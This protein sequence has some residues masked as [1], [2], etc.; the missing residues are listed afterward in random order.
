MK[1]KVITIFTVF[2]LIIGG[3]LLNSIYQE[4]LNYVYHQH[5]EDNADE[6]ACIGIENCSHLPIIN[7]NTYN[8]PIPGEDKN[9]ENY[10][11]ADINI[12][13]GGNNVTV[14]GQNGETS[15]ARLRYRGR[16]SLS[17]DKKGYLIKF[18]DE[19]NLKINKSLLGMPE[20]SD[21]V[22]HG[23]FIDK[24][25]IRNYMWYNIGQEIMGQAPKTRFIELYVD[26]VYQGLY[27]AVEAVTQS[28]E[29]RIQISKVN[30][31]SIA[32]SYI[33][34]LDV[35]KGT[36][37]T[38]LNSFSEYT[39]KLTASNSADFNL[40]IEYP[41]EEDLTPE[42]KRYILDDFSLF[43]KT[44]YSLDYKEYKEYIN[45]DNFVDY[46]II[47]EFTQNYDAGYFSTY[48]YKDVS[49]KYNMYIWDFNSANNNYEKNFLGE[50]Q[51]FEFDRN[52]WYE[53]LLKDPEFVERIINRYEELRKTYLSEE[54]LYNYIEQT[55]KYLGPSIDRNYSVWGY[56]LDPNYTKFVTSSMPRTHEEAIIEL[57]KAIHERGAWLDKNIET[58]KQYSHESKNKKYNK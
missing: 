26:N 54:F 55:T 38:Y 22:L 45:V 29:S 41:K 2:A 11:I 35:E 5:L 12:Y 47:N 50:N 51:N 49:G 28:K 44:L 23:P 32:N 27:L 40:I 1:Y 31:Q 3:I 15:K 58:L 9:K 21:W 56:T 19:Q 34:L 39:Y 7:I 13:D 43:E 30:K 20:E 18:I 57:K 53:M 36:N 37:T 8:Q 17:F 14:L 10:I 25:L 4:E 33:I 16:S 46:F 24:S 42:I 6:S 52:L 48:I